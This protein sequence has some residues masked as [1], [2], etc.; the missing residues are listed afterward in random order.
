MSCFHPTLIRNPNFP[1]SYIQV[2]CGKC[3][4]CRRDKQNSW[5]IR[6]IEENKRLPCRFITL[7]YDD[8]NIP[9]TIDNDEVVHYQVL[10]EDLQKFFKRMRKT[11][12][13]KY[14]AVSEYGTETQRPHYHLLLFSKDRIDIEHYWKY[15]FVTDLPA[16]KGAF[17]YCTKYLLKGSNVP[18]G[19]NDNFM[20]CSKRPAIGKDFT[21]QC[22]NQLNRLLENPVY[23]I[24]DV[25]YP[26]PRY[27]RKKFYEKLIDGG[28]SL[29]NSIMEDLA[30][31]FKESSIWKRFVKNH[32]PE[33]ED[34]F[35]WTLAQEAQNN[36]KQITVKKSSKL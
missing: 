4:G 15:G 33:K 35:Q 14:F 6:F 17:R 23:Y 30:S 12:A 7:T 19:S 5:Y 16:S 13:F 2:P 10:K 9:F 1:K 11:H 34:F 22:D 26:L 25:P 29:K 27:F 32:D 8:D 21:D 24:N 20:L 36:S 18:A 31:T 3:S 28:E